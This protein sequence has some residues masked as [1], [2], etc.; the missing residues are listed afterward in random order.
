MEV[1]VFQL[2]RSRPENFPRVANIGAIRNARNFIR[3]VQDKMMASVE[4]GLD[5]QGF[6]PRQV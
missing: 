3:G 6:D 2:K 1:I 5:A 4:K